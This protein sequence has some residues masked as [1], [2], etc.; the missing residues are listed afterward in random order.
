[1]NPKKTTRLPSADWHTD[2]L[3]GQWS[4]TPK[5][6]SVCGDGS[7]HSFLEYCF[8]L[9]SLRLEFEKDDKAKGFDAICFFLRGGFL[10]FSYLNLTSSMALRASIFGGMNHGRHPK[11]ELPAY[12]EELQKN[13]KTREGSRVQ[14]L[15]VDEVRSGTGMGTI[16]NLVRCAMDNPSAS[17]GCDVSITFYAVRPGY[18]GQM[19][20]Q[21]AKVVQKWEGKHGTASGQLIVGVRHFAGPLLGYDN[22]LL[23]GIQTSS[24]GGD[25][26]EAYELVKLSGGTVTMR[27]D[28]TDYPVFHADIDK[29]CLVEFLA[30]CA[31]KWTWYPTSALSIN[32]ARKIEAHGCFL[33]QALFKNAMGL[34]HD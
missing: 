5:G 24:T 15:M 11:Q 7:L 28:V 30:T 6:E 33:C 10:A 26:D 4:N 21:L 8:L 1:M 12:I 25:A 17:N 29:N 14:I 32:L 27:C 18:A 2:D 23:C 34:P 9:R 16:L 19:T 31:V 22:D 3:H 13:A 20:E